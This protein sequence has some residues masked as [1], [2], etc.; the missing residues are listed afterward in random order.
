M[1]TTVQHR[2]SAQAAVAGPPGSPLPRSSVGGGSDAAPGHLVSVGVLPASAAA[3]AV[4]VGAGAAGGG[5]GDTK[6]TVHDPVEGLLQSPRRE[7]PL[8]PAKRRSSVG[9]TSAAYPGEVDG[10]YEGEGM[11]AAHYRNGRQRKTMP[12]NKS[13]ATAE[14]A[15]HLDRCYCNITP[16]HLI[17][18]P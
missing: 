12:L 6:M 5:G 2:H 7:R 11:E 13:I 14:E 17:I 9:G 3:A 8:N 10:E 18:L 4:G 16:D 1:T 15:A